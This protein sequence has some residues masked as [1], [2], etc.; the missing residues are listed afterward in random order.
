MAVQEFRSAHAFFAGW[1]KLEDFQE[2]LGL[3]QT[4]FETDFPVGTCRHLYSP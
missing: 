3:S 4:G 1:L 2:P